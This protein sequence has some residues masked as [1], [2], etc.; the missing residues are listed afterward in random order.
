MCNYLERAD[1][2]D[3]KDALRNQLDVERKATTK[4]LI[5]CAERIAEKDAEIERLKRLLNPASHDV[6]EF[7]E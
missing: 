3:Q 1:C 4:S 7:Y 2:V 5:L 6:R